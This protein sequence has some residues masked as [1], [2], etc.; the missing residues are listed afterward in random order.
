[1]N[2]FYQDDG[3][4]DDEESSDEKSSNSSNDDTRSPLVRIL[5]QLLQYRNDELRMTSARLLFDMHKRESILFSNALD[6]YICTEPSFNIFVELVGLG[7]LSDEDKLLVKMHMGKLGNLR[8]TL[9]EKLGKISSGCLLEGDPAE[10][11]PS[12]QGIT[13]S[14]RKRP[15]LYGH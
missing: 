1:M 11:H 8:Q 2:I 15:A 3:E 10:P 14:T 5:V 12:Y 13:Y 6:S 7:S 9:L 4:I